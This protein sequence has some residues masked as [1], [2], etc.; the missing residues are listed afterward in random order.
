MVS[1]DLSDEQKALRGLA[2]EF[3]ANEIAPVARHY[4]QTC[5]YPWPVIKKAYELGL[6]HV[7]FPEQHGGGGLGWFEAAL[8]QE[9]TSW[10][11][12]G[13][14]TCMAASELALT[15]LEIAATDEQRN[16]F[17]QPVIEAQGVFAFCLTEPGAGSDVAAL[18]TRAV[19]DG[20]D[21]VIS[22]T[23]HF[24]S[25]GNE[26][27]VYT[28][29]AS[30]DPE[31]KHRGLSCFIVPRV[32][33]GITSHHMTGKL[34]HRASDTAEVVFEEVRVPASQRVGREGDGFK[35]AML[36]FDRTRVTVGAG[37]V[38][39]ARAAL[40]ASTKFA[41]ERQQFGQ[42]IGHFQAIQFMLAD[43]AMQVETARMAVWYA[44]W[45][46]DHHAATHTDGSASA[47]A[48]CLGSDAAMKC[49]LDAV[50]IHGGYGYFEEFGVEKLMRDAKLLQIYEGTNQVQRL[51]I[52]RS[53][54]KG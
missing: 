27:S 34:G 26:A 49:A 42:P 10:G 45:L 5:E 35:I 47:I 28:V 53:L 37:G 2:H 44:A 50:Q 17:V 46:A 9:E 20:D 19:K 13:I 30:T 6:M 33:P 32:T 22:G 40:E 54:L 52:A 41:L 8:V 29:F 15:P 48:K 18:R 14:T 11:C 4:D 39:V 31:Q 24:I 51:I 43:M 25:N 38:G 12:A 23:K 36:T 7:T 16:K 21:Y 3:A 1:F